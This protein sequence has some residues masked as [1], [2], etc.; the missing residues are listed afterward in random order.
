MTAL[1]FRALPCLLFTPGIKQNHFLRALELKANGVILDIEDG[2]GAD[3]KDS[4]RK[5]I[6]QFFQQGKPQVTHP[7]AWVIR[8]NN[9]KSHQGLKDVMALIE[10][11]IA[12]D[13]I[14]HPKT[15]SPQELQI[16]AEWLANTHGKI[17]LLA[18]IESG[19]GFYQA[20]QIVMRNRQ[21]QGVLFGGADYASDVGA[22]LSWD[23]LCYARSKLV[24]AAAIRKIAIYDTPYFAISDD[25]GLRQEVQQVR[26]LGFTGK[27]AI[28]PGQI[29]PIIDGFK[30]SANELQEAKDIITIFQQARGNACRYKDN[31]I[32]EPVYR[33]ALQTVEMAE[34]LA[35]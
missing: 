1:N 32:D 20:D 11:K 25:E 15:E 16:L 6:I 19:K 8:I 18:F 21:C 7:F 13:A 26:K 33:R 34:N 30:P 35:D 3:A 4:T 24:Q 12:C 10:H 23:S 28:H 22:Q 5:N 2:V 31:M 29:A 14:I 17:P 27:Q 9:I